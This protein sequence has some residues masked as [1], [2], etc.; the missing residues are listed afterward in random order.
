M[1]PIPKQDRQISVPKI[2]S[3]YPFP[4]S[5]LL[6]SMTSNDSFQLRL[7]ML[8]LISCKWES[9]VFCV[10]GF[11]HS[12]CFQDLSVLLCELVVLFYCWL[13]FYYKG[14]SYASSCCWIFELFQ[15]VDI[16]TTANILFIVC[17]FFS[18]LANMYEWSCQVIKLTYS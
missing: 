1:Q 14:S 6:Q 18:S 3:S 13:I 10:T 16:K 2:V 15:V 9:T 11:I 4:F 5:F 17:L 12:S 8:T 7:V